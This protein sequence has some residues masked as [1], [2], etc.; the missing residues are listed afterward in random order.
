MWWFLDPLRQ[1]IRETHCRSFWRVLGIGVLVNLGCADAGSRPPLLTADMPLHLEE[2]LDA[3]VIDGSELPAEGPESLVWHFDEPQ[4]DWRAFSVAESR[5]PPLLTRTDD[6]LRVFATDADRVAVEEDWVGAGIYTDSPGLLALEP[7]RLLVRARS[8]SAGRLAVFT[9]DLQGSG[10]RGI[11]GLFQRWGGDSPM[12]ADGSVQSYLLPLWGGWGPPSSGDECCR[13]GVIAETYEAGSVD[14][15]SVTVV[16]RAAAFAGDPLG[17]MTV[18]AGSGE[19]RRTL[20]THTPGRV[21][22]TVRV[23]RGGRLDLGLGVAQDK[24][25]VDFRVTVAGNGQQEETSLLEETL[26]DR[27]NWAQRSVDLSAFEGQTVTLA[28]QADAEAPGT[29][30]LWGAPTLSGSPDAGRPNVVF[31]IIDGGSAEHMSVYGYNRRT[32]PNLERLAAEGAVFENAYSNSTW[33]RVS[34]PSFMTGLQHS[35][36]GGPDDTEPLP[37]QAVTMA[38]HMHRGGY[39]TAALTAN[40]WAGRMSGLDRG[41]DA[42]WDEAWPN[43]NHSASSTSM[44]RSFWEWRE[45]YPAQPYWV[46]FQSVDAHAP[47]HPVAPFTGLFGSVDAQ[48]R[49]ADWDSRLEEV[50][51]PRSRSARWNVPL[52]RLRELFERAGVDLMEYVSA[53][54]ALYDEGMAHN[55]YQIGRLVNRIKAAG[56]WDNTIFILAADHSYNNAGVHSFASMAA[57]S[58]SEQAIFSPWESRIPMIVVWPARIA[59]GQS[60]TQP[61]SMID[62]LPTIVDL[63]GLPEPEITQG[64]SLAPLLLGE[65]GWE[66]RPVIFDEFYGD[67]ASDTLRGRIDVVDGRWG[68]SLLVNREA[69]PPEENGR[70]A[71]LLLFD[72]WNDPQLSHSLH[73]ERPDLVEHYT[74]FLETQWAAHRA[75]AQRFSRSGEGAVLTPEQLRTLRALGYIN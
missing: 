38:E 53:R 47:W 8:E 7:T 62:M 20:F 37:E 75:L 30:V 12:I 11:Y 43:M 48:R 55:D 6:A 28:L 64:Q 69:S 51:W 65:E 33:T 24:A 68:A 3:A 5:N 57:P 50:G 66:P 23:P 25:P 73:E 44:H 17:V 70:A 71:P 29:V 31:Y 19:H 10:P 35:V 58:T 60:F 40:S 36:L 74:E 18:A 59:A 45:A 46:H 13:I 34:T 61:V 63:A 41:V 21:A 2:H 72:L 9:A 14:I 15:L 26:A 22:F 16:S 32:T 39:Q 54:M 27:A 67:F 49:I 4:P 42:L 52:P 1:R 56:E